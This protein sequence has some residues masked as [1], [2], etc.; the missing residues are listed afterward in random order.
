MISIFLIGIRRNTLMCLV[1]S[2]EHESLQP[3]IFRMC[4]CSIASRRSS[5][6]HDQN[7]SFHLKEHTSNY[8]GVLKQS[9]AG[10]DINEVLICARLSYLTAA[11]KQNK[12]KK[13]RKRKQKAVVNL[14]KKVTKM[15]QCIREIPA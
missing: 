10:E 4:G 12:T 6:K 3:F 2:E 9:C 7:D 13:K 14:L 1:Q 11:V 5:V 15:S 8:L